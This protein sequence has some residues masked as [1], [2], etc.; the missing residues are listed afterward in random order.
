MSDA[1]EESAFLQPYLADRKIHRENRTIL[2][3]TGN[4]PSNAD[5]LLHASVAICRK[6]AIVCL[7]IRRRRQNLDIRP[8]HF[9]LT[10]AEQSLGSGAEQL[11]SA[12][13][14]Y[15]DQAVRHCVEDDVEFRSDVA[16]SEIFNRFGLVAAELQQGGARAR[17]S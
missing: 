12:G 3:P 10:I 13:F 16:K 1:H 7:P 9:I 8:E 11:N 4:F 15:D 17:L 2:A 6:V 5:D 14:V